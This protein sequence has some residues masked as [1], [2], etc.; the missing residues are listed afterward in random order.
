MSLERKKSLESTRA[1]DTRDEILGR[2][3]HGT[4][5]YEEEEQ[6]G[7]RECDKNG[8]G[9]REREREGEGKRE[10][11]RGTEGKRDRGKEGGRGREREGERDRENNPKTRLPI[12]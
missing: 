1:A 3:R 9:E 12:T 2:V 10:R 4:S 7:S 6:D 11:E 8:E 5:V